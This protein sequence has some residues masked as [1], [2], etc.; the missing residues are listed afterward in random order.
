MPVMEKSIVI[1]D[2]EDGR[3]TRRKRKNREKEP[4]S[5][6]DRK[7]EVHLADFPKYVDE[8]CRVRSLTL[9]HAAA[10][11]G[12]GGAHLSTAVGQESENHRRALDAVGSAKDQFLTSLEMFL[13]AIPVPKKDKKDKYQS[14]RHSIEVIKEKTKA[15]AFTRSVKMMC[16]TSF[17]DTTDR[18][19]F[20]NRFLQIRA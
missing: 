12:D 3:D 13:G 14:V 1:R 10:D 15:E 7:E 16:I 17:R 5:E 20:D 19:M 11:N 8:F 18:I 6:R 4:E 2:E 9:Q